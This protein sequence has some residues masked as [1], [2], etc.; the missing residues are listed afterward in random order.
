MASDV[1]IF[2]CREARETRAM[3][4]RAR[5]CYHA[6]AFYMYCGAIR[7]LWHCVHLEVVKLRVVANVVRRSRACP[8]QLHA[9]LLLNCRSA[10]FQWWP[11]VTVKDS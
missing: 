11:F 10:P 7:Q 4:R 6:K 8:G 1:V 5:R 9:C 2:A 3:G